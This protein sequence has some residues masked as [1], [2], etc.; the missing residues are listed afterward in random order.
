MFRKRKKEE[1]E[2]D[3]SRPVKEAVR[4]ICEWKDACGAHFAVR[5]K[6]KVGDDFVL[7]E[8]FGVD[9]LS[10]DDLFSLADDVPLITDYSCTFAKNDKPGCL[11]FTFENVDREKRKKSKVEDVEEGGCSDGED[12]E[13]KTAETCFHVLKKYLSVADAVNAKFTSTST[14]GLIVVTAHDIS[15]L[16]MHCCAPLRRLCEKK[17]IKTRIFLEKKYVQMNIRKKK[18][19]VNI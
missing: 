9:E 14:P 1:S 13:M 12:D 3:L 7:L 17:A 18:G 15:A 6:T 8:I 4:K 10:L 11:S 2:S 19:I 16:D 5:T